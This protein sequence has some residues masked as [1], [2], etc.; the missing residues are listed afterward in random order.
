[1]S[2]A[3]KRIVNT[4]AVHQAEE[5]DALLR[6]QGAIPLDYPC[7]AIVPPKDT[8]A[9]DQ[10]LREEFDLLILTSANTVLMLAQRLETL[11]LSLVGMKAAAVGAATA[12]AARDLIG[13]EIGV[14]PDDYSADAL[15][16]ALM[17]TTGMR[18]LLPQSVIAGRDLA[19]SLTLRGADVSLVTAYRT[20]RGSGG[21]ELVPLLKRR[22]VDAV[23]F[24]SSSTARF[25]VERLQIEGASSADLGGVCIA[26]IGAQTSKTVRELGLSVT[27]EAEKH[28]LA[29]LIEGLAA[30]FGEPL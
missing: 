28:T 5:F 8:T 13:V 6:A 21:V 4:R 26:S 1:V 16:D 19:A 25:F 29:G 14:I 7:I 11:G 22:E 30:H 10:A 17:V 12:E 3:G 18:I 15:A 9:L 20:I 2:L 23:T 27:V 24:T